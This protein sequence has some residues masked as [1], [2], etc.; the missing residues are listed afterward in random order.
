MRID[1]SCPAEI[2]SAAPP[3]AGNPAAELIL[4]NGS[5]RGVDSCEATVKLLD[6]EGRELGRAVH[7]ARALAGRPFSTFRMPVPMEPAEGTAAVEARLDK[8]WFNDRDVWRRNEQAEVEY[9]DNALPPGNDLNALKYVAGNAAVG[10]PS[11][12]EALW[13]C[14]CGRPNGNRETTC[15]RCRRQRDMIFR[16]YNRNAVLRQ[17]SQR[18]RQLDLKTRG[19][20]E[21]AA[22]LQRAREEEYNRV[23]ARKRRNRRLAAALAAALLICAGA[24][25]GAVPALRMLSADRAVKEGRPEQAEETLISLGGFPGA[26]SRLAAA[27]LAMAR[28]DGTAAV[29]GGDADAETL[30]SAA[31]LLRSENAADGD[32]LLADRVDLRRAEILLAEGDID[33]AETLLG[34]LPEDTEGRED[35][36]T[37]CAYARAEREMREKR[38][39]AA[40]EIFLELGDYRDSAELADACLYEPALQMIEAGDYDGAIETLSRI[41]DYLDSRELIRKSWYLKG[42]TLENEGKSEEARQAYLTAGDYEDAADR[43]RAIRWA[44][45]E[46]LLADRNYLGALEIYRELDGD[47]NAREKLI[48]CATEAARAAYKVRDYERAAEILTGLPEDTKETINIRTRAL[49]LGAKAAAERG[50]KEKAVEMMEKVSGYSDAAKYIRNW[51]IELAQEKMDRGEW[52]EARRILEPIADNYN[53]Q[54]LLRQIE[55]NSPAPADGAE[56]QGGT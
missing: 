23:Q 27:R 54:K 48:F 9:E 31:K 22:Q 36:L 42:Y 6:A 15:A 12:Q 39:D 1:L 55:K 40:R 34:T 41:P 53:A 10:F 16:Q 56:E 35:L 19:A 45:A 44:Q 49:Y 30:E 17:I 3:K 51:R 25:Y 20:R 47:G 50:E 7:R 38:Y 29:E 26:A 32:G 13:V 14:V 43:A 2:L 18:E 28:R 21:E 37:E 11:Q 33:G 5:D 24:Y 8:V 46:A 52:E 4:L